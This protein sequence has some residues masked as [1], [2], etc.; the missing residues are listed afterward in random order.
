MTHV[1]CKWFNSALH[2]IYTKIWRVTESK[3]VMP[4]QQGDCKTGFHCTVI[5]KGLMIRV[6]LEKTLA[7]GRHQRVALWNSIVLMDILWQ[8][9]VLDLLQMHNL[10]GRESVM[11]SKWEYLLLTDGNLKL[12]REYNLSLSNL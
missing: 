4:W 9:M 1:H 11:I 8:V 7:R 6:K 3:E 10:F 5:C 2:I 12:D